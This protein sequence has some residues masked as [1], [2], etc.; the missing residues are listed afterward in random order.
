MHSHVAIMAECTKVLLVE[1]Q[2]LH[3]GLCQSV[4][5]RTHMVDFCCHLQHSFFLAILA[6]RVVSQDDT[7]KSDPS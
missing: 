2:S 6:K 4:F 5:N 1:H 3:V 7:S